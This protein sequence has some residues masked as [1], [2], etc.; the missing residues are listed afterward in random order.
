[1]L[2][3]A[4]CFNSNR[5][6][7]EVDDTE[8]STI[9]ASI[10]EPNK[11]DTLIN[12]GLYNLAFE[13]IAKSNL[14]DKNKIYFANRFA[15]N[16]EYDKGKSIISM[17]DKVK[18]KHDILYFE[19]RGALSRQDNDFAKKLID[20][21]SKLNTY[22]LTPLDSLR[23][24][25][26]QAYLQHNL[27]DYK[28]SILLNQKAIRLIEMRKLP[29]SYLATAYRRLGNDYNDIVRN[30][31]Q[32]DVN[33]SICFQRCMS[34]YEKELLI[35]RQQKNTDRTKIAL[36]QITT[37]MLLRAYQPGKNLTSYY[38]NALNNLIVFSDSN[39]I[40]TRNPIYTSIAL[41]QLAEMY[42]YFGRSYEMDSLLNINKKLLT[43]RAFY[44]ID[45]KQSLDI[46]E[47]FP[48]RSLELKIRY[49]A[50]SIYSEE[51]KIALLELSNGGKYVN[52][53][54]N[55]FTKQKIGVNNELALKNWLLLYEWNVF[56]RSLN[57]TSRIS[58]VYLSKLNEYAK[59]VDLIKK[60]N[61][62]II[63]KSTIDSI[64]LICRDR[65]AT[66]IDY[67]VLYEG[68]ILITKIDE[69][70]ITVDLVKKNDAVNKKMID[71]L[72]QFCMDNKIILYQKL[73]F[74]IAVRL[75]IDRIKTQSIIICAD[76]FLEKIPFDALVTDKKQA[77]NWSDLTY[78]GKNYQL[79][80]IPNI[81]TLI[82]NSAKLYTF[83]I[84]IWTSDEDNK[85]LPYNKQLI[86]FLKDDLGAELNTKE[87]EHILHIL[88][89]THR[90]AENNIE[91][92]LDKDTLTVFSNQRIKP[93]L[94]ILEGCSS[95][96]GKNL[97]SEGSIN[98][99]RNFLYHGTPAVIHA[100]WDADNYSS[101]TLFK[102]F[103]H[104]LGEGYSTSKALYLAKKNI[105]N[106]LAHPE[107]SNPYYWANF[108]MLGTDQSFSR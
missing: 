49:Y 87:P 106:D 12:L 88:A 105:V 74:D 22:S 108:Q 100:I 18:N 77:L 9:V 31:V 53:Y 47:Y 62:L 95:A 21:L 29:L 59:K 5:D 92:W 58:D 43:I 101:T 107:W 26:A 67:Q 10:S 89:H 91:F 94:A 81:K 68:S 33:R 20:S 102:Y 78:L 34:Y 80:L 41:T 25:L 96:D 14:T 64:M 28:N 11:I 24:L 38:R 23:L 42:F 40:I 4:S 63:S 86:E 82:Y 60:Q 46:L 1:M 99:T 84:D 61:T 65:N 52:Q 97:K 17:I 32:F 6:N 79:Q 72:L 66:F 7:L 35:L 104:Y 13:A 44:K 73:A 16:G 70:N 69:N 2:L 50:D 3:I 27:G 83:K 36:N 8:Y 37:A 45:S 85:T 15:D 75:R 19:I 93:T 39:F 71:S 51:M 90:N 54:L 56:N 57:S 30:N 103:Y 48:Q 55:E 76:E 98:Q